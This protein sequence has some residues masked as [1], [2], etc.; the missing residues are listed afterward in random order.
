MRFRPAVESQG[1][2][3]KELLRQR[4]DELSE[5]KVESALRLIDARHKGENTSE[6]GEP[7]MAPLPHPP[8]GPSEPAPS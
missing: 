5:A 1:M 3:A 6:T 4:V 8:G 2:L 7:E